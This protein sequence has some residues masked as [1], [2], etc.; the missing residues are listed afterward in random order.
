VGVSGAP[1]AVEV[2]PGS[3]RVLVGAASPCR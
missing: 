1:P 2:G 3:F